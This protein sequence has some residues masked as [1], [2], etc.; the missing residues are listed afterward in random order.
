MKNLIMSRPKID[1]VVWWAFI[2]I[3]TLAVMQMGFT[4][5]AGF[6]RDKHTRALQEGGFEQE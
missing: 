4:I 3:M 1:D 2:I 6:Y 5:A